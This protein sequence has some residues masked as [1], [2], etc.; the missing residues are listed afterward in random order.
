MYQS[1]TLLEFANFVENLVRQSQKGVPEELQRDI[2]ALLHRDI[3]HRGM[4]GIVATLSGNIKSHKDAGEV[5]S[6]PIHASPNH[7]FRP[8]MLWIS[9]QL[10][11][12]MSYCTHLLRDSSML[13]SQLPRKLFPSDVTLIKVDIKDYYMVGQHDELIKNDCSILLNDSR[14]VVKD[15]LWIIIGNQWIHASEIPNVTWLVSL[16]AGKASQVQAK[17]Q[18]LAFMR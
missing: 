8:G 12:A 9:R 17:L 14:N 10:R 1:T 18:M 5:V 4:A 7:P 6:R 13:R 11:E 3:R 16:G 2:F 15:L